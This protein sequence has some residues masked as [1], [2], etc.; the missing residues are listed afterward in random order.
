MHRYVL[1]ECDIQVYSRVIIRPYVT[2][3]ADVMHD[4]SRSHVVVGT[5]HVIDEKMQFPASSEDRVG[6][7]LNATA[8]HLVPRTDVQT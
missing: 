1:L 3:T 6:R 7:R 5:C 2:F 4:A 8:V